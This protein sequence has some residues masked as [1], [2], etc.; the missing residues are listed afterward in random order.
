M[1]TENNAVR[2]VP[3]DKGSVTPF[4]SVRGAASFLDFLKAAFG[5]TERGRVYN[6]DGTIGHAEVWI[7][8][9]VVM[10]FDA[11]P[12]WP[13]TPSLLTLYVDDC[14][15]VHKQALQAGAVTVTELWTSAWGDRCSR[16]RD[17]FGNIWWLQ[18]HVE[19]VPYDEVMKRMG[20]PTY[21]DRMRVAQETFDRELSS[22]QEA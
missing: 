2:R 3:E 13:D 18:T 6:E 17:P 22:R 1:T 12:E 19:D 20:E 11:K 8:S 5:A 9:T 10:M 16:I 4:I 21:L 7:G 14:D 15:A